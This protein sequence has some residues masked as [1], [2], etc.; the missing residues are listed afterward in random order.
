MDEVQNLSADERDTLSSKNYG[1]KTPE[2]SEL[3]VE[4]NSDIREKN[5]RQ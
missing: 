3:D 1:T 4:E 5:G 2:L